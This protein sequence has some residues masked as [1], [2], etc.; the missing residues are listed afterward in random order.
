MRLLRP[1]QERRFARSLPLAQGDLHAF[2]SEALADAGDRTCTH[3]HLIGDYLI[4]VAIVN[5]KQD[6]CALQLSDT[7]CASSCQRLQLRPFIRAQRDEV[8]LQ[9]LFLGSPPR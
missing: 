1:V 2:L 8:F 7:G 9:E 5:A 4:L 6:E 3:P